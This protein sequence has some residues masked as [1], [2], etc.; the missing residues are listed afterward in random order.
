M[1]NVAQV[2]LCWFAL[3]CFVSLSLQNVTLQPCSKAGP[4]YDQG[5][6]VEWA[7]YLQAN[8]TLVAAV[9][10]GPQMS[11]GP[12][13]SPALTDDDQQDTRSQDTRWGML[14]FASLASQQYAGEQGDRNLLCDSG[15]KGVQVFCLVG[16]D[17][18]VG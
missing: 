7:S 13:T 1:H 18:R 10:R 6:H 17:L 9:D 12:N 15:E 16:A 2:L 4:P 11:H 8:A 3:Q 14:G 5:L